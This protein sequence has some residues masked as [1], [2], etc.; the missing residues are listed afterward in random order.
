MLPRLPDLKGS[1]SLSSL[2]SYC[3]LTPNTQEHLVAEPLSSETQTEAEQEKL[4]SPEM[5]T[6]TVQVAP[7]P[8]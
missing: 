2:G 7:A 6:D 8:L 4:L 3:A 5:N 1:L